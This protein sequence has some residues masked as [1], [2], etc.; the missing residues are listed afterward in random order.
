MAYAGGG[1]Q[2]AGDR[3]TN[4]VAAA[5]A[6][7]DAGGDSVAYAG[8]GDKNA[9]DG[10]TDAAGE[11]AGEVAGTASTLADCGA[12]RVAT[13]T[14]RDSESWDTYCRGGGG[15][16]GGVNFSTTMRVV[17]GLNWCNVSAKIQPASLL[18]PAYLPMKKSK[19][20]S[21]CQL[22]AAAIVRRVWLNPRSHRLSGGRT[23]VF[24]NKKYRQVQQDLTSSD[25]K[26][27]GALRVHHQPRFTAAKERLGLRVWS[28]AK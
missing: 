28:Q 5:S 20:I 11:V 6:S 7:A 3:D 26:M 22:P 17:C 23:V 1:D 18:L 15:E 14:G 2:N 16:G 13:T 10:D 27:L 21:R 8:G 19:E 12:A 9:G 25:E 24:S 4:A